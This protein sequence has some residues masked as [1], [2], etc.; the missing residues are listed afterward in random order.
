[1]TRRAMPSVA[2][3]ATLL[4][5][6]QLLAQQHR[7][8]VSQQTHFSAEDSEVKTPVEIPEEVLAILRKDDHVMRALRN[9][10]LQFES[11]PRSWFSAGEAHLGN[12]AGP[13]FV[14]EA[15]GILRGANVNVFWV[16]RSTSAGPRL[17]M[18]APAHDLFLLNS[19]HNGLRDIKL[20]SMTAVRIN[21][22]ILRFDGKQYFLY[23][24]KF[25]SIQ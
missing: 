23:R 3:F 21:T 4:L 16:V 24:T 20:V 19:H 10:R 18:K 2:L 14:I 15:E 25:E 22:S 1:M 6:S 7:F 13:D 5:A 17:V 9:E 12:Q 8:A 11:L